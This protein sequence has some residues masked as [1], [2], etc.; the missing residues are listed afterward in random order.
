MKKKEKDVKKKQKNPIKVFISYSHDSKEHANH[1]L[2]LSDKLVKDGIDCILDQY[3]EFLLGNWIEWMSANLKD[4][5][6][7]IVICTKLYHKKVTDKVQESKSRGVKWEFD[8]I[9]QEVYDNYS[10]NGRVIPVLF[11][12]IDSKFIPWRFKGTPYY[13]VD[14]EEGYKNLY[15]KITRQPG[16][17]K[18]IL[19][20]I[21]ILP[22]QNRNHNFLKASK[23]S[24]EE[25]DD[26]LFDEVCEKLGD[27]YD[28]RS[29]KRIGGGLLSNSYLVYH[30]LLG[31]SHVLKIM[32]FDLCMKI[33][34]KSN[35]NNQKSEF[36]KRRERFMR[37]A[38]FFNIFKRHPNIVDFNDMVAISHEFEDDEYEVPYFT[39]KYINGLS[40]KEL[41]EQKAPLEL[42]K[43]VNISKII[44]STLVEIH[45]NDFIYR[46][47]D[48]GEII[49]EAGSDNAIFIEA[50]SPWDT[51]ISSYTGINRKNIIINRCLL[52][53]I[54]YLSAQ[55]LTCSKEDFKTTVVIC[56]FGT[57][58]YGMLTGEIHYESSFL[59]N[60]YK[61]L[62]DPIFD[63][64]K[65][66]FS[67]QDGIR[68]LLKK[69]LTK[70]PE[71]RYKN[72]KEVLGDL[73]VVKI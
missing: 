17:E 30:K 1:V 10:M 31:E 8:Y 68:N 43:A 72:L 24:K 4:A 58:L 32:D 53:A 13:C 11:E 46:Y 25:G 55:P 27:K 35:I 28:I 14:T 50:A 67:F 65:R 33:F 12:E 70:N 29:E 23:N 45:E 56:L 22:P 5:N 9:T 54:L 26:Y 6:F 62:S 44:L 36:E 40:L 64:K 48:P 39:V 47:I 52:N 57:L 37:K 21:K 41:I 16:A 2:A 42:K 71:K 34:K 73:E 69:T 20:E 66:N 3:D 18:P 15:R 19:G 60:L 49:I 7:V 59:E 38:R 63:L 61:K 51:D